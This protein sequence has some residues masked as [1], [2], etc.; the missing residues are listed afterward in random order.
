[1]TTE[2]LARARHLSEA[3]NDD[4]SE[5]QLESAPAAALPGA[6]QPQAHPEAHG[7]AAHRH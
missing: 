4:A 6:A 5:C 3:F 1:L 7:H 2:L